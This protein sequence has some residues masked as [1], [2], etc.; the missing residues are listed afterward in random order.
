VSLSESTD[1]GASLRA[2]RERR[3]LTLQN[4][5]ESTKIS[6]RLLLALES[7]KIDRLPGG[8][9]SRSFVR[10]YAA[11]VG[12]DPDSTIVSFL[13][14][15][16]ELRP[17]YTDRSRE[18]M[19]GA[20]HSVDFGVAP[21]AV[22]LCLMSIPV[23]ALLAFFGLRGAE[24]PGDGSLESPSDGVSAAESEP[25]SDGDAGTERAGPDGAALSPSRAASSAVSPPAS[26]GSAA[27]AEALTLELHPTG[28]CW[29]SLT[30][31]GE[32]V[33]AGVLQADDR[34]VYEAQERIVLSVGN[35]GLIAFSLN[36]QL[37]RA[38]GSDGAVVTVEIDRDNYR[39][40]IR[41]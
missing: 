19:D 12:L 5:S 6:P 24:R 30:I 2:A 22:R 38:L 31:D 8:L 15:F 26:L 35:A 21:A 14:A 41:P 25:A 39:S 18:P 4:L 1:F 27:L 37:G 11:E 28:P 7:N 10:T 33:F 36:Q 9:F 23:V 34:A 17:G 13:N 16:P 32:R 3:G 29:V 40:F 20:V